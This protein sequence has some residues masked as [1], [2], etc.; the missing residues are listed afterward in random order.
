[1]IPESGIPV[2][3]LPSIKILEDQDSGE[4]ALNNSML[5]LARTLSPLLYLYV[6]EE[7]TQSVQGGVERMKPCIMGV[8]LVNNAN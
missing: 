4:G 2:T 7:S 5:T 8:R 3:R 1:M 6:S